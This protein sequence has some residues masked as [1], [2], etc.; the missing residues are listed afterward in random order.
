M[1]RYAV[2][3]ET[4]S[5]GAIAASVSP[6][7]PSSA[8]T[9]DTSTDTAE[10]VRVFTFWLMLRKYALIYAQ[11]K[12]NMVFCAYL[13]TLCAWDVHRYRSRDLSRWL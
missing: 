5:T 10:V 1:R 4:P 9:L 8:R 2:S 6:R 13:R 7:R 3:R 11:C 12:R